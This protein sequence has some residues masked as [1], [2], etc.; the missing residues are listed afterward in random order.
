MDENLEY[1]YYDDTEILPTIDIS[2]LNRKEVKHLARTVAS[3]ENPDYG[4][5]YKEVLTDKANIIGKFSRQED[6]FKRLVNK[7]YQKNVR[8][9][10]QLER[11][12]RAAEG[13]VQAMQDY[14]THGTT[15]A[16]K[17]VAP[18][19]LAP[20][21]ASVATSGALGLLA[22]GASQLLSKGYIRW[23][24]EALGAGDFIYRN[25]TGQGFKK[26]AAKFKEGDVWGGL[27]SASLD[28]LDSAGILGAGY[29]LYKVSKLPK[30]VRQ[31]GKT[32]SAKKR[33][34][35][36]GEI[37]STLHSQEY[38][39]AEKRRVLTDE[40]QSKN[41][42]KPELRA[43]Y[44]MKQEIVDPGSELK[45]T[46]LTL[47]NGK[48]IKME[49]LVGNTGQGIKTYPVFTPDDNAL[50]APVIS[51]GNSF[52]W[53][54]H[55][56]PNYRGPV[57][58]NVISGL[59]DIP[60]Q[61]SKNP[62]FSQYLI[63]A[64]STMGDSGIIGGSSILFDRGYISG[65]PHDLE[66]ISTKSRQRD[67]IQKIGFDEASATKLPLA[68]ASK[69]KVSAGDGLTDIQIIDED[70]QG[71]AVGKLA[72][73]LY[74]VLHPEDHAE[75]LSALVKQNYNNPRAVSE[76]F[77]LPKKD[78]GYYTANELLDEFLQSGAMAKKTLVDAL[79]VAKTGMTY[80]QNPQKLMRPIGILSNTDPTLQSEILD[81]IHTLGKINLG[82][83]YKTIRDLYPNI[84]FTDVA[85][86]EKF[87]EALGFDKAL[88]TNPKA[89][90]NIA[91][92]YHMQLSGSQRVYGN[93][94]TPEDIEKFAY[95][96]K[97]WGGGRAMGAGG[98]STIGTGAAFEYPYRSMG[99]FPILRNGDG[100]KSPLDILQAYTKIQHSTPITELIGDGDIVKL[101]QLGLNIHDNTTLG[102]IDRQLASLND[103]KITEAA[104]EILG[105]NGVFGDDYTLNG[106]GATQYF[107]RYS[108]TPVASTYRL[109]TPNGHGAPSLNYEVGRLLHKY[110]ANNGSNMSLEETKDFANTMLQ[111]FNDFLS[112]KI[113][114]QTG[115]YFSRGDYDELIKYQK[116]F[117]EL[118][119]QSGKIYARQHKV[120]DLA[121]QYWKL[122]HKIDAYLRD[123]M[124]IGGT[125][126]IATGT[127][128]VTKQAMNT[129][130]AN[131]Y[132]DEFMETDEYKDSYYRKLI[133]DPEFGLNH[134]GR[135]TKDARKHRKKAYDE[136]QDASI[137][138]GKK[139]HKED[140][141]EAR[142]NFLKQF[143]EFQP[144]NLGYLMH[145]K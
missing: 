51:F 28:V 86:N 90:E 21:V 107:G 23:P 143:S 79:S 68:L 52:G 48:T 60:L 128:W 126:L 44:T 91:E 66:I 145:G 3:R 120:G 99:Q 39:L 129:S 69:S 125:G 63:D 61:V 5:T 127:G 42:Q 40:M 82:K 96:T 62:E 102:S 80:Q 34:K 106:V 47:P 97:D 130:R 65:V 50:A 101:K 30:Y 110:K 115:L 15:E 38:D 113:T 1:G 142:K 116:Q 131:K 24:L 36:A 124:I 41:L 43:T 12:K 122:A 6:R 137:E 81:A 71:F 78:G 16:S 72:H 31:I 88:A 117:E 144:N 26:T 67:L 121:N 94:K 105:I 11:A 95:P 22:K 10:Q 49:T 75:Y 37:Y 45:T 9:T 13:D 20:G 104:G 118:Q 100:V 14:I 57:G 135:L 92:Y 54:G 139:R 53:A 4:L 83:N 132:Y 141:K 7:Q 76:S 114:Q 59:R 87:L 8:Y 29:D 73:E 103:E 33:Y 56:V 58:S 64:Q 55:M 109:V 98:N 17:Y 89:M 25:A 123:A 32:L 93:P 138:F 85:K 140:K 134:E 111:F 77:K 133:N 119:R 74:R 27:G 19:V 84:D 108:K 35:R 70:P 2:D 136:L 18:L 112:G 46:A